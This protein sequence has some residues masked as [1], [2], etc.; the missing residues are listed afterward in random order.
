VQLPRQKNPFAIS[1]LLAEIFI[2]APGRILTTCDH[3]KT[4]TGKPPP[5]FNPDEFFILAFAAS[6][7]SP[8][9]NCRRFFLPFR[10]AA[11]VIENLL[12]ILVVDS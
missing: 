6:I 12:L 9:K 5:I 10:I 8:P 7:H 3:L 1:K 4:S 2:P 11:K